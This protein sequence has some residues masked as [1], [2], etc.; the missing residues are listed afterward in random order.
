[1]P[2]TDSQLR[3]P[4]VRLKS[5]EACRG[6]AATLVLASHCGHTLGAP[7][8][9]GAPPFGLF[10]QFGRSGA[11]L[12]FV[13]SGFLIAFIHWRDLDHPERLRHYLA[14]R[15]T[16]IYPTYWMI[17]LAIV[18]IDIVTNT[19]YDR[20]DEPWEI[21]KNILLLPQNDQIIDVAWSLCNELLFYAVFGLMILSRR[22]GFFI[23]ALWVA[24]MALR[25][26][27]VPYDD[28]DWFNL[29]TYPMNFEFIA[30]LVTGWALQR[31]EFRWPG[32]ML[33][34][35]MVVFTLFAIAED[36]RL[37]WSNEFH[38]W[39]P[40]ADWSHVI[41]RSLGYGSAGVLIIGGL[42]AMEMRNRLRIPRI[43][44][45]LG[46]ASYLLYL[47]HVPA[48]IVL[49]AS[50]RHLRL[51]RYLPPWLL[52]AVFVLLI[53]AGAIAVHLTIEKPLLRAIRPNKSPR[54]A[55]PSSAS[56]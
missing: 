22:L 1:V 32:A 21:V 43:L 27:V 53:I 45:V 7:A 19:F 3:R 44:T 8:N 4:P 48:L 5:I 20:Y 56:V 11:D 12:F 24:T 35:G 14:R 36:H 55:Q 10:F 23:L 34:G 52:A 13:L 54:P 50:E 41:L 30:G 15:I 40:A 2:E 38:P 25:P 49:G 37:L 26:I 9:F 28:I 33:F 29:L 39:F 6:V 17:L 46:G 18:P 16:R 31:R 47:I 42:A 51:L